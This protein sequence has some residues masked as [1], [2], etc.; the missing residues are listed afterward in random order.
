MMTPSRFIKK[1]FN[2][3][4]FFK[5]KACQVVILALA[6]C[7]AYG[8]GRYTGVRD[9]KAVY[10]ADVREQF[11]AYEKAEDDFRYKIF[12]SAFGRG[13]YMGGKSTEVAYEWLQELSVAHLKTQELVRQYK[14]YY[15]LAE[16]YGPETINALDDVTES[17]NRALE[18]LESVLNGRGKFIVSTDSEYMSVDEI[19]TVNDM[20]IELKCEI[21][22]GAKMLDDLSDCIDVY[23]HALEGSVKNLRD[24]KHRKTDEPSSLNLQG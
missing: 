12:D 8:A 21:Q 11:D 4:A 13:F 14:S 20:M 1:H 7:F 5:R 6:S 3:N 19:K 24:N 9:A 15:P 23:N 10:E 2:E 17:G 18:F 22:K 16:L